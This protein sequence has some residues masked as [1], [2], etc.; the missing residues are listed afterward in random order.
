MTRKRLVGYALL[1]VWMAV[2]FLLSGEVSDV[3]SGRSA[4][5][6]RAI[7]S[8]DV[9]TSE[10]LLTFLTRKAAHI[11]AYFILGVLVYYVIRSYSMTVARGVLI[12]VIFAGLY[13]VSDEIHQTFVPGRSGEV[14]D[15][16]IDTTAA[17]A[18]VGVYV[19]AHNVRN[20]RRLDNDHEKIE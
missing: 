17:A 7:Q 12:A 19:L 4:A 9:S 16:L 5:I 11:T 1:F 18:G 15:V 6:V 2:I 10:D 3:S 20:K 13:A 8:L 14:R